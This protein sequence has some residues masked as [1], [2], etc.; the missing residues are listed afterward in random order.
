MQGLMGLTTYDLL[1]TVLV[2]DVPCDVGEALGEEGGAA[3]LPVTGEAEDDFLGAPGYVIGALGAALRRT[4]GAYPEGDLECRYES[5]AY[6][7][8]DGDEMEP[9]GLPTL[10]DLMDCVLKSLGNLF[11]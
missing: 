1:R 2:V 8:N 10:H 5:G 11:G 6:E 9:H 7:R 3:G 4:E